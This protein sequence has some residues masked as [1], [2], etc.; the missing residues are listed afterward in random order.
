MAIFWSAIISH[1]EKEFFYE[2]ITIMWIH[3]I[4]PFNSEIAAGEKNRWNDLHHS[5]WPW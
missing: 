2:I 3:A 1:L 5:G 4:V